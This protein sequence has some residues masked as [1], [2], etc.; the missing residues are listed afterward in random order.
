MPALHKF[1]ALGYTVMY[2]AITEE[3]CDK[4]RNMAHKSNHDLIWFQRY[5]RQCA[6]RHLQRASSTS[7]PRVPQS[8]NRPQVLL[9]DIFP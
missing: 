3:I 7:R 8:F 4:W 2:H 5:V 9:Q 6:A 1:E